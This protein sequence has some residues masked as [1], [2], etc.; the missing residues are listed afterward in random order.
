VNSQLYSE[1]RRRFPHAELLKYR[2]K[3]V[4]FSLDASR[5][6]AASEDLATLD[7]RI[8]QAGEDPER[9]ALERIEMD[10]ISLGAGE[11]S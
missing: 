4:A 11:F 9:E 2:G 10:D 3:W 5:I 1:N 6:I 7:N 8:R